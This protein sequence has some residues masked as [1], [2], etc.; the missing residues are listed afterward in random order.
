MSRA[1]A[2]AA[3]RTSAQME[4]NAPRN[5]APVE[6]RVGWLAAEVAPEGPRCAPPQNPPCGLLPL[7]A[8]GCPSRVSA[9]CPH[10]WLMQGRYL[11]SPRRRTSWP[12]AVQARF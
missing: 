12:Q 2:P 5:R 9:T 10:A 1:L 7:R 4:Y 11:G 3:S 8:R 6:R